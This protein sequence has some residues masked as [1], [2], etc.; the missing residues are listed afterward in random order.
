VFSD[1]VRDPPGESSGDET[2][3]PHLRRGRLGE[4]AALAAYQATGYELVA[5]NWTSKLG[6]LDLVLRRGHLL[7]FCEVKTRGGSEFGGPHEAVT[8][9]KRQK[10]RALAE[11]FLAAEHGAPARLAHEVRFD[12]ASVMVDRAGRASVHLFEGA[13]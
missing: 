10:L 9:R 13:F 2:L 6:E 3:P 12:V 1:G 7:V 5:R 4:D 11:V 8:W